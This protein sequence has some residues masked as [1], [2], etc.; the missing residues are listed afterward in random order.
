M[1]LSK[2]DIRGYALLAIIV[3]LIAGYRYV[4]NSQH[5]QQAQHATT[6]N[7]H[8]TATGEF[9]G[10]RNTSKEK[11]SRNIHAT[12]FCPEN[13]FPFDPNTADSATLRRI[14]FSEQQTINIL[15]YRAKGGRWKSA[16]HFSRL[17][18]L[19]PDDYE[20]LR[21]YI[22]IKAESIKP[23][24]NKYASKHASHR[25]TTSFTSNVKF[26]HD[27]IICLNT[28]DTTLLKKIP[29]IGSYYA[30]RICDY[31]NQLGGFVSKKQLADIPGLPT[32]IDKWFYIDTAIH[33]QQIP[34]NQADFKTLVRHPYLNYEQTKA[35]VNYIRKYGPLHSWEELSAIEHF[36][37][38]D[39][40]RL[41]PYF[42]FR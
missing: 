12:A 40:E 36:T 41:T 5:T 1:K 39:L 14:G 33:V 9:I 26:R 37:K 19:Q 27:T 7:S 42:N 10:E 29:G 34:I 11:T 24:R 25:A 32:D 20:L 28:A 4:K 2:S 3:L 13:L 16:P 6:T 18:T 31:R 35:I 8:Q 22:R 23:T 17:Y 15:K 21:P 30:R 38:K